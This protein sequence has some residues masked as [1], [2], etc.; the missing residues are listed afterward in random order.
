[1]TKRCYQPHAS[2]FP[3]THFLSYVLTIF[4]ICCHFFDWRCCFGLIVRNLNKLETGK[5]MKL[6]E[7]E[8]L[9]KAVGERSAIDWIAFSRRAMVWTSVYFFRRMESGGRAGRGGL[10]MGR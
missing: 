2:K 1:M 6:A 8:P 4:W 5:G 10:L 7:K 3:G 9:F